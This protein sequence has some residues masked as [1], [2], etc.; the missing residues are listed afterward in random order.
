[1]EAPVG[2]VGGSP[3]GQAHGRREPSD[4]R[5]ANQAARVIKHRFDRF[6]DEF[7][8][9]T[10]QAEQRFA[11]ANWPGMAE[12]SAR[13]LAEYDSQVDA[14]VLELEHDCGV[15]LAKLSVWTGIKAVFSGLIESCRQS[16]LAETFFNSIARRVFTTQGVD[17][18]IEFVSSDFH[19]AFRDPGGSVVRSKDSV[20]GPLDRVLADVLAVS[21]PEVP[22]TNLED[23]C[24]VAAKR[25]AE[26]VGG[27]VTAFECAT[28]V[29]YRGM[30]AYVV[31][32]VWMGDRSDP[33]ALA[34]LHDDGGVY[35]DAVL[36][37]EP[38]LS[39]LFSFARS[40]FH[41]VV[42]EPAELVSFLSELMPRKRIAELYVAIG[43]HKHGK[44][45]LFRALVGHLGSTDDQFVIAEGAEGMVMSVFAL[46]EFEVVFKVI[47][48]TF[49]PQK[50]IT[51]SGVRERYHLVFN[52]DRVG[53]LVDAHEFE[54]LEFP[55]ARFSN[56]LLELLDRQCGRDVSIGDETVTLNR[57]YVER[58]VT[59]LDIYLRREA[60]EASLAAVQEYGQA[61]KDLIAAGI[62]PGDM[63]LKNFGVTRHGRVV[64]YDYDE[65]KLLEGCVFRRIPEA[66]HP[67]DEMSDAPW[68][69]VGL[70]DV[71]PEE[72]PAYLG[73]QGEL[74][75]AF[76]DAHR[77]LFTPERWQASQA[78]LA[79]G[80]R[81]PIF[82][83]QT[84]S[85]LGDHAPRR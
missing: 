55:R 71:F 8:K 12:D 19:V 73:L 7:G 83:Y 59:P 3:P 2:A 20:D 64:F 40:Y 80:T 66:L 49:P 22:W 31:G 21:L 67:D 82:P 76:L 41:V 11:S 81:L 79:G 27:E 34:V 28:S 10:G 53:R 63:L 57:V 1:M 25:L 60:M 15:R 56:E 42:E 75:E 74:R 4:S 35:I 24:A 32:R 6:W 46:P 37:T 51:P 65:L 39:I 9:L 52:H 33:F 43:F 18:Q 29:F 48:D 44:T 58:R 85:R 36:T 13:R 30:G 17:Q 72:F 69:P 45:E 23:D 84:S 16:E 70:N 77:D 62:F 5:L 14:A 78:A 61:I 38:E 54:H 68:F 50:Q 47:K 26:R